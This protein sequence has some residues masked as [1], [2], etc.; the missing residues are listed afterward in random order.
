MSKTQKARY[1][2]R[3]MRKVGWGL[4]WGSF[5]GFFLAAFIMVLLYVAGVSP[6]L[7]TWAFAV[8]PLV[9][10]GKAMEAYEEVKQDGR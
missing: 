5:Q 6:E 9:M 10:L 1:Y 2:A 8:W 7:A 4:F 3:M